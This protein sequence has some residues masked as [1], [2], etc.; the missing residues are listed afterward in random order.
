ML[1]LLTLV[2][3]GLSTGGVGLVFGMTL[4]VLPV[5]IY[6]LLALWIDRLEKEPVW[7]LTAAFIW[8]ATG[9]VFFAFILNTLFEIIATNIIGTHAGVATAVISAPIVEELAKGGALLIFFLWK[10]DEFDNVLDGIIYAAMTGLGF[11]MT[12]NI[13]Y[14]GNAL[15]T[16]GLG[17]SIVVFVLRGVV[18]PFAHPLFTSMTG[19]ALGL[20]QQAPRRSWRKFLLPPIGIAAAMLLHALWN[21]S[22]SLGAIFFVS[23]A[24]IMVPAFLGIIVLVIISLR[25]EG[26]IIRDQLLPELRSGLLQQRDYQELCTV[27]G[28]AGGLWRAFGRGGSG[29]WR[30]RVRLHEIASDLAFH[31]WRTS[32]GILPRR[33]TPAAR[34][35]AYLVQLRAVAQLQPGWVPIIEPPP[36]PAAFV[37]PPLPTP[38][39]APAPRSGGFAGVLIAA[40][41]LGC[42][43]VIALSVLTLVVLAYIGSQ[44]EGTPPPVQ[45]EE[46][47]ESPVVGELLDNL[48]SSALIVPSGGAGEQRADRLNRLAIPADDPTDVALPHRQAEH[49]GV[50]ARA[51]GDDHLIRKLDEIANDELEKF[52]HAVKLSDRCVVSRV[53]CIGSGKAI[54]LSPAERAMLSL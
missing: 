29:Q 42:L 37:P 19:I 38:K 54:R 1:G 2:L 4:A 31:R 24:L 46:L 44:V 28:R 39:A 35:A 12:E 48:E 3:L 33:E 16:G 34:E 14:Y 32:R 49:C 11:A 36:L 45:Q 6:M 51:L 15:A 5:P 30:K 10:H 22:A 23:Y 41:S 52:F 27:S 18:S 13:L 43:G 25:K 40:S 26:R 17:A 20:A 53:S 9:A 21:L 8:G 7:M 50:A 47:W